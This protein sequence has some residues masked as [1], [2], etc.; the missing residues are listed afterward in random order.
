[1]RARRAS[2]SRLRLVSI[3]S[4]SSAPTSRQNRSVFSRAGGTTDAIHTPSA[5][6]CSPGRLMRLVLGLNQNEPDSDK[7]FPNRADADSHRR[8]P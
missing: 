2:R 8:P 3:A 7:T 4:C 5:R 1:M 6:P